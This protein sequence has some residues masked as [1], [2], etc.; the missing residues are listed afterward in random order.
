MNFNEF[1]FEPQL[2]EGIHALGFETATPIQE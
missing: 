1:G 2:Q